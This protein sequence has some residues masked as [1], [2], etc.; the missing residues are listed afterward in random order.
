MKKSFSIILGIFTGLLLT[1]ASITTHSSKYTNYA[2]SKDSLSLYSNNVETSEK[3]LAD[4]STALKS[5]NSVQAS[6]PEAET[7]KNSSNVQILNPQFD[8]NL[9]LAAKN[10]TKVLSRGG[11]PPKESA[12]LSEET[13]KV[14]KPEKPKNTQKP[15]TENLD[16]WKDARNVFSKGSAAKVKDLYTGKTFMVKRTMGSNHADCEALTSEDTKIIKSIWEGFSWE[17][18]PVHVY[19]DGRVLAASMSAMPHAGLDSAPAYEY[20]RNRSGGYGRGENLDVIKDND[21]DGH[22]DIHF[23]NSTRHKDGRKDPDHQSMIKISAKK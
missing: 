6:S 1:I 18:R 2:S 14:E 8:E 21:M 19:I 15:K 20:I 9:L 11:Q 10:N 3:L 17:R 4:S 12:S 16:W 5:D 23:L 7:E 22:F 13:E